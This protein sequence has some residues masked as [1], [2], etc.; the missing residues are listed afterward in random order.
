LPWSSGKAR[1]WSGYDESLFPEGSEAKASNYCRNPTN[2]KPGPWCIIAANPGFKLCNVNMCKEG[3]ECKETALGKEYAGKQ[4]NAG[5]TPCLAWSSGKAKVWNNYNVAN[6]PEGSEAEAGNF[7][8]NPT[9]F[10]RGP[11]C[12][13]AG[14]PGYKLCNIPDCPKATD[15]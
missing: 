13:T 1:G 12:I 5:G 6:F 15:E 14:R 7:C 10:N 3:K 11:W 4:D 8:R 2:Y 9:N